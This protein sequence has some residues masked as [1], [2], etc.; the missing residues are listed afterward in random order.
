MPR[1]IKF[2]LICM[3]LLWI[4]LCYILLKSQPFTPRVGFVLVASAIIVFVP[5]YKKY[6]RKNNDDAKG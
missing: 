4:A 3:A 1:A 5:I 6:F 2:R